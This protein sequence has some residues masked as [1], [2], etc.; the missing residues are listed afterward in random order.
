MVLESGLD[1]GWVLRC[2]AHTRPDGEEAGWLAGWIDLSPVL[3]WHGY[4]SSEDLG[5]I[6]TM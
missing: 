2:I 4:S 5:L 3:C 1:W 6:W